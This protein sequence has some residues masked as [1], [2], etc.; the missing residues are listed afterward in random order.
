M[1][2]HISIRVSVNPVEVPSID[3]LING[4]YIQSVCNRTHWLRGLW[5]LQ[6]API[7]R[8]P[9]T[10]SLPFL[11]TMSFLPF[12]TG[13][14]DVGSYALDT[15][16]IGRDSIED[17][18][19]SRWHIHWDIG[20]LYHLVIRNRRSSD[21]LWDRSALSVYW[22]SPSDHRPFRCPS[23]L[24]AFVYGSCFGSPLFI[25][26]CIQCVWSVRRVCAPRLRCGGYLVFCILK[27]R[28][29]GPH[30]E[31]ELTDAV[32]DAQFYQRFSRFQRISKSPVVLVGFQVQILRN[33]QMT[34]NDSSVATATTT[35]N[36][37]GCLL[38]SII[39]E[40]VMVIV[41]TFRL[42]VVMNI[43]VFVR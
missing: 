41:N 10:Y 11:A 6:K 15:M 14:A 30:L 22:H 33:S 32:L 26:F 31:T 2:F 35:M 34:R 29:P 23:N 36:P 40:L 25:L 38:G 16:D 24:L 7:Y 28:W 4:T 3:I 13:L 42:L 18:R 20:I 27:C 19:L 17:N 1:S 21:T 5:D 8:I 39:D 12:G 37:N 9:Q 43:R